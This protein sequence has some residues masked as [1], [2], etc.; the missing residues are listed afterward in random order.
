MWLPADP[1]SMAAWNLMP[2]ISAPVNKPADMDVVDRIAGD[3]T[4]GRAQAADDSGLL[5]M[6]NGVVA[7]DVVADVFL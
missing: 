5:A 6:G 7:N 4:E 2:A 3:G 1:T